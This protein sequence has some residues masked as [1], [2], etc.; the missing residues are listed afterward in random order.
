MFSLDCEY[1]SAIP[2]CYTFVLMRFQALQE[3]LRKALWERIQEGDLTGLRLARET[4]F[5]QAHISNFLHRKRG[6][7]IEGMDKVLN[8]ERS[9]GG[10]MLARL[11]ISDGSSKSKTDRPMSSKTF[12]WSKPASLP[13]NRC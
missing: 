2:R 12:L 13:P 5:K 9:P 7:S 10:G 8:V 4:G 1:L 6:L 11:L 3:N